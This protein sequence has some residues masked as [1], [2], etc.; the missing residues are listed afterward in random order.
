MEQCQ[1]HEGLVKSI[2]QFNAEKIAMVKTI[3]ET[4]SATEKNIEKISV[5]NNRIKD[6][7]IENK[8]LTDLAISVKMLASDF[9]H[10]VEKLTEHDDRLASIEKKPAEYWQYLMFTVMGL[11]IGYLFKMIQ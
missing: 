8:N 1:L 9:N 4:S 3:R 6:L 2:D 11:G 10:L 7:E 5:A